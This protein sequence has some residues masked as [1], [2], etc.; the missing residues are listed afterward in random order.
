[1]PIK[2]NNTINISRFKAI[3]EMAMD[4]EKLLYE[5]DHQ[6]YHIVFF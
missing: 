3:R 2:K 1:M 4:K 6:M 5:D